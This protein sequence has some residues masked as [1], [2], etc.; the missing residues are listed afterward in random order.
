MRFAAAVDVTSDLRVE[1]LFHADESSDEFFHSLSEK[2][3]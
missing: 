2:R 1:L 3:Q